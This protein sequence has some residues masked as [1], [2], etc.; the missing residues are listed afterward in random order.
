M[1]L[2]HL[3]SIL[4]ARWLVLVAVFFSIVVITGIATVATTEQYS[5]TASVVADPK[6]DPVSAM[7][8]GGMAS[9]A[10]IAT[11]VDI[12]Q[13]DRVAQR[14]V[15]NLRLNE[16][17]Q[18]RDQW[19]AATKGQGSFDVW[20]AGIFKRSMEVKPSRESNVIAVTYTAPDP[21]FAAGLANAFVKAY[22]DTALELR[23]DPAKQYTTFF[24]SRVKESRETLEQ[25]QNKLSAYQKE[26]G[27]IAT[28]ERFDI[29]SARLSELSSQLVGLQALSSESGSRQAQARG[30][31]ADRLQEVLG[32]PLIAG[33]K[34]DLSRS[35]ARLQEISAR[36]GDNHPQVREA[37]ASIA[38][39]KE[40]IETETRRVTGGVGVT[41]SINQQ[42]V[43]EVR[44]SLEAQ[45][46]KVLQLKAVRDEGAVLMRDVE[47]A[48][49]AYDQLLARL[50]QTTLESQATLSSV[51]VLTEAI[52]PVQPSSPNIVLNTLLS[53]FVGLL[54]GVGV[55]LGLELVDRRVRTLDDLAESLGLPVIGVV[56]RPDAKKRFARLG[57]AK[58]GKMLAAPAARA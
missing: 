13:S 26:N 51:N 33:L 15:R 44:A 48:Q 43:A 32:N 47:N 53:L 9:A 58:A 1:T 34:G 16:N 37:K 2:G 29:E 21:R 4:R 12:I 38:E 24:E 40:R 17:A 23:V 19:L 56:P 41:N 45:R 28:D 42:R 6:P 36:L 14:V 50:N 46:A 27:I 11:Q 54:A 18:L 25:A 3:I 55:V 52:P 57:G 30:S 7:M 22:I 8:Y 39:L 20:M 5:A 35:E 31:S 10:F 49:R